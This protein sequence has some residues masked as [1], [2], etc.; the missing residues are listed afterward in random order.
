LNGSN[1]PATLG[2]QDR[3][4]EPG[5]ACVIAG[6]RTPGRL[7]A[8]EKIQRTDLGEAVSGRSVEIQA[9]LELPRYGL[10]TTVAAG[11]GRSC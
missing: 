2:H 4:A 3:D 7:A 5:K 11:L 1:S 8:T 10:D 6:L 9:A